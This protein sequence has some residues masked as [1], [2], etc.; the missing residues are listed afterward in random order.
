V[1]GSLLPTKEVTNDLIEKL[2][3]KRKEGKLIFKGFICLN[4]CEEFKRV[5]ILKG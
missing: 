3:L 2:K 5:R 1:E 4:S